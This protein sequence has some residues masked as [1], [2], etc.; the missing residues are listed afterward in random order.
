MLTLVGGGSGSWSPVVR[1]PYTGAWQHNDPL[2]TDSAL[3]NPSVFG[4][5][6]RIS[7]DISKIAPPLLLERDRN[8]FWTETSNPAYSPVLRRPNRYQLTNEFIEYK[9]GS[10]KKLFEIFD[11]NPVKLERKDQHTLIGFVKD[12][13]E[14][15]SNFQDYPVIVSLDDYSVKIER[16]SKQKIGYETVALSDFEG[17]QV[18]ENFK[19]RYLV[20]RGTIVL[21]D[22]INRRTNI[23]RITINDTIIIYVPVSKIKD[24]VQENIAG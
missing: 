6:S 23:V 12:R 5:V 21:I 24:K 8:N 4:A 22:S 16:P 19:T 18:N 9:N 20:R 1:E 15:V 7:Q 11:Y 14:V 10:L 3:A 2:T 17:Y 13:D